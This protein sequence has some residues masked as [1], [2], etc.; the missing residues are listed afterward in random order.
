VLD[1]GD[2]EVIL[3]REVVQLRAAADPRALGDEGR[4]RAGEAA[5][6]QQLD[7]RLQQAR[8]HRPTPVGL[9][10]AGRGCREGGGH[11]PSLPSYKQTVKP[12]FYCVRGSACSLVQREV[13]VGMLS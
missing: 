6:H 2:D 7:R 5:L 13:V 4:R 3:G 1:G 10:H 12:D 9:R 8:P 11:G